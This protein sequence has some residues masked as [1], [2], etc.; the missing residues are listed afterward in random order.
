M[1]YND[2]D[3]SVAYDGPMI[4]LTS[5][6]SAS[7]SEILAG[8]LQDYGRAL[9][10]GDSSTHGKGTVQQLIEL[11]DVIRIPNPGAIKVTIRNFY[12][13]SG[14]STQLK[15]VIPDIILPSVLNYAEVGEASL[16]NPVPYDEMDPAPFEKVNIVAPYLG[17]LSTRSKQRISEDPDYRYVAEDI[18]QYQK[19]L[20]DKTVSLNEAQRLIEKQEADSRKKRRAEEM[21]SRPAPASAEI[22]YAITLQNAE[23]GRAHV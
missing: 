3:S 2:S 19:A 7:A 4:V 17:E 12:R 21:K 16:P 9:I 22:D 14:R 5:R 13:P 8:A 10:V 23:I 15:G 18:E 6:F 1:I 20:R 11:A